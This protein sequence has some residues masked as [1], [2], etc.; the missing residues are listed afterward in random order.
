VVRFAWFWTFWH[1]SEES[2]EAGSLLRSPIHGI[3]SH[4]DEWFR[5]EASAADRQ[6]IDAV[7]ASTRSQ[8]RFLAWLVR[9]WAREAH[10]RGTQPPVRFVLGQLASLPP[11]DGWAALEKYRAGYGRP[12]ISAIVLG[13]ES[14]GE[15]ADVRVVE[16]VALPTDADA[17]APPIVSEGFEAD[18]ATLTGVRRAGMSLLGGKGLLLFLALWIVGGRRPYPRWLGGLLVLGWLAVGG[19]IARLLVGPEPGESLPLASALLMAL[20]G[21]LVLTA[22]SVAGWLSLQAWRLGRDWQ[23]RL[24]GS[25]VRLRMNGGLRLQGASAGLSFCLN[26]MLAIQRAHPRIEARSWLWRQVFRRLQAEAPSWAATGVVTADGRVEP[27]VLEPK[28]RAVFRH[29]GISRLLTPRQRDAR[30]RV[31]DRLADARVPSHKGNVAAPVV[32]RARLGFAAEK[33]R[34]RSHRCRHVAQA[35]MA[36]GD[37]TSVRQVATNVLA[38]ALSVTMV[39]ALPDLLD[40]VRPPLAPAVVAPSSPS[41]YHLWVSLDTKRPESFYVVL[42]SGFWSNRR[43]EVAAYGG[44][45]ASV[46]A[47]MR[48]NRLTRQTSREEE[49]GIVWVERRRRFLSRDFA[50]GER[51][52]RYTLS[53][54]ARLGHE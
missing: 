23:R 36:V 32:A 11:F 42:E 13:E 31:V 53:Y 17:T 20:W 40:V 9:R 7:G 46:R 5:H 15:S 6:A 16:A 22:V 50:P 10:W 14:P 2:F 49:D 25:Q 28:L 51:V 38:L 8:R 44:A 33:R 27:V 19:L 39:L 45:N 29:G 1:W 34:L 35:V 47:E 4:W 43:A 54:V 41:P 30:Q 21:S 24:E 52:G 18:S 26:T 12:G 3:G 48:L 37:L